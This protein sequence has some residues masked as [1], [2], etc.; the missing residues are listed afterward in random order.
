MRKLVV[1]GVAMA[2]LV[3]APWAFAQRGPGQRGG[4]RGGFGGLGLLGQGSVQQ[5]LKLNDEQITKV[6]EYLAKQRE[7]FAESRDLS[8]EERREWFMNRAEEDREALGSLLND[9]QRKRFQEISL[10]LRG[11]GALASPEVS[12]DL[13]LSEE[14]RGRVG[15]I[16][17]ESREEMRE[18]FQGGDR[19]AMREKF[20]RAREATNKKLED[21]LT[22]DQQAKWKEMQGEP[23]KGQIGPPARGGGNRRRRNRD[24]ATS[25]IPAARVVSTVL[26]A[27]RSDDDKSE[28][29][30]ADQDN[31]TAKTGKKQSAK[32]KRH[33]QGRKHHA[34]DGQGGGSRHYMGRRAEAWAH[35]ERALGRR[36]HH[37]RQ[38]VFRGHGFQEH[39]FARGPYRGRGAWAMQARR[40][41]A[42]GPPHHRGMHF[43]GWNRVRHF[44]FDQSGPRFAYHRPHRGHHRHGWSHGGPDRRML[45]RQDHPD[46]HFGLQMAHRGGDEYPRDFQ[47]A[48]RR[49]REH[50][51]AEHGFRGPHPHHGPSWMHGMPSGRPM[52][53]FAGFRRRRESEGDRDRHHRRGDE[54]HRKTKSDKPSRESGK[55][56]KKDAD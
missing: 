18:L 46:R 41:W 26:T 9:Q 29:D 8:R 35:V 33:A 10:Q 55:S 17:A 19:S 25:A 31:R 54:S 4:G 11:G 1:L 47:V 34:R 21:V 43:A 15:E 50:G 13:G 12:K 5:E 51:P 38:M 45:A 14:Q 24:D 22:A 36:G 56:Q 16:L 49:H 53:H 23:F 48:M 27:F 52:M 40:A 6:D 42:G 39:R 28:A 37:P 30:Q 3:C 7:S 44:G 32:A 20:E 2:I